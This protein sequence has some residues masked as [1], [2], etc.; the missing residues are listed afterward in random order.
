MYMY[1]YNFPSFFYLSKGRGGA[2]FGGINNS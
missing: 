2:S 1:N